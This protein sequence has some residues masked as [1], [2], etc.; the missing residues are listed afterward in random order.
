MDGIDPHVAGLSERLRAAAFPDGDLHRARRRRHRP[1]APLI[2]RRASQVIQVAVGDGGQTL[3]AA[4]AEAVE[5]AGA[6]L[7]RSRA[8]QR[9]VERIE[10]GEQPDVGFGVAA[11]ERLPGGAAA[12]GDL[13]RGPMLAQ[14]AGDLGP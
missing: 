12:V 6:E 2:A 10:L 5:G 9:A 11:R 7:A 1:A 14:Q 8:G 4:V 3:E 13:A